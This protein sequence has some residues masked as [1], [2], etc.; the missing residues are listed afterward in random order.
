MRSTLMQVKSQSHFILKTHS[1][2]SLKMR[3]QTQRDSKH[4]ESMM[5]EIYKTGKLQ[6]TNREL[7]S[8]RIKSRQ[9]SKMHLT[10][11]DAVH[12]PCTEAI[13]RAETVLEKP[14]VLVHQAPCPNMSA[15]DQHLLAHSKP[16]KNDL[17]TPQYN[18]GEYE[19]HREQVQLEE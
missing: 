18:V 19:E 16:V 14:S 11:R 1:Q 9:D 2:K 3:T 4:Y 10:S 8:N 13:K 17:K 7:L 15:G 6:L 12:Y 5:S